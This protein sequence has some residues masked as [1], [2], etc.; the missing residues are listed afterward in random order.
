MVLR[1]KF[2]SGDIP[3]VASE[4]I[5]VMQGNMKELHP[6]IIFFRQ[7]LNGPINLEN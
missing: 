7:F 3:V 6:D 2:S 5:Q 1:E 4:V